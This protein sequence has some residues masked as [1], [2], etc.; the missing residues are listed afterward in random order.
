MTGNDH[1]KNGLSLERV[2]LLVWIQLLASSWYLAPTAMFS[3]AFW[4]SPRA[5]N[6][7]V[8]LAV[9][10]SSTETSDPS[11]FGSS[12]TNCRPSRIRYL[13]TTSKGWGGGRRTSC[14]FRG[15]GSSLVANGG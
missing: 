4:R 12:R 3:I 13:R 8:R 5:R 1:S 10:G 14:T 15:G 2:T 11:C 7:T 9:K 6:T